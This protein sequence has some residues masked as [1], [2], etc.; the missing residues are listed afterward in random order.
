AIRLAR[1]DEDRV[2]PLVLDIGAQ[3]LSAE[4]TPLVLSFLTLGPVQRHGL[5]EHGPGNER[6][7]ALCFSQSHEGITLHPITILRDFEFPLSLGTALIDDVLEISELR[8]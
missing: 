2:T 5:I 3:I 1:L 7:I 8:L 4:Q 6:R